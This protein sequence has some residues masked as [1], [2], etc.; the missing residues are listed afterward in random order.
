MDIT[1]SAEE[2][3]PVKSL[4]RQLPASIDFGYCSV[5]EPTVRTFKLFNHNPTDT[6]SFRF[7]PCA[8]RI[9][10]LTGSVSPGKSVTV[11]IE[12]ANNE[13]KI[14]ITKT[15]FSVDNEKPLTIKMSALFKYPYLQ[16]KEPL[17]DM[18]QWLV[19][20]Q[21]NMKTELLNPS[22]VPASFEIVR[23]CTAK[24]LDDHITC[25]QRSGVVPAHSSY[26]LDL[27]F[28]PKVAG[29]RSTCVFLVRVAGGIEQRM[30]V[31]GFSKS[32]RGHF[33]HQ[34][35]NFGSVKVESTTI[36]EFVFHND[37][38]QKLVFEFLDPNSFFQLSATKGEILPLSYV[39]IRV[40][41]CPTVA[42]NYFQRLFCLVKN[43]DLVVIEMA[44]SAF[45]VLQKPL[46]IERL[47]DP[48]LALD[49]PYATASKNKLFKIT[50]GKMEGLSK[51]QGVFSGVGRV[52]GSKAFQKTYLRGLSTIGSEN[53]DSLSKQKSIRSISRN[54]MA[55]PSTDSQ[56]LTIEKT[57]R[58]RSN[59]PNP[60]L[61]MGKNQTE[62]AYGEWIT[63]HF[64]V[65]DEGFDGSR[66]IGADLFRLFFD[67]HKVLNTAYQFSTFMLD[68]E[69][70]GALPHPRL[71]KTFA[72]TNHMEAKT[73][74]VVAVCR[75]PAFK[76]SGSPFRI[77]P[78]QTQE[79]SVTFSPE[80][81]NKFFVAH[82]SLVLCSE[83]PDFP[84][85]MSTHKAFGQLNP[86][87]TQ[88]MG[89]S[90]SV[91]PVQRQVLIAHETITL[92]GDSFSQAAKT[93]DQFLIFEP[94]DSVIFSHCSVGRPMYR[95]V[96]IR[97]EGD[98][99]CFFK[100]RC[101]S[102]HFAVYPAVG[103]IP[104][105]SRAFL[106]VRFVPDSD[107]TFNGQLVLKLNKT[108]RKAIA[109][110]AEI[111]N[112]N[113]EI[114]NAGNVVLPPGFLGVLRQAKF[115]L[116]NT[117][118]SEAQ[119]KL[120]VPEEFR[121]S[122]WF[123]PS[124]F[125][126][127]EGELKEVM[128]NFVATALASK[129][130]R[131]AAQLQAATKTSHPLLI[132]TECVDGR[133]GVSP[134][135]VD[136]GV[137]M[138]NFVQNKTI[139]IKNDSKTAFNVFLYPLLIDC[140][141]PELREEIVQ[142]LQVDFSEGLV[143]EYLSQTV[144]LTFHPKE[145]CAA[146]IRLLVITKPNH[147]TPKAQT[148]CDRFKEDIADLAAFVSGKI[149]RHLEMETKIK[150][151]GEHP[152]GPSLDCFAIKRI[153]GGPQPK[154]GDHQSSNEN[155]EAILQQKLHAYENAGFVI[156]SFCDVVLKSN[157]PLLKIV[158]ARCD[159]ESKAAIWER[160]QI[161]N[162][163]R[164]FAKSL[165]SFEKTVH[166]QSSSRFAHLPQSERL[167]HNFTW[168]F[169]FVY[170]QEIENKPRTVELFLQ[171]AGGTNLEWFFKDDDDLF[172]E[173]K[174]NVQKTLPP[175]RLGTGGRKKEGPEKGEHGG[176]GAMEQKR[177]FFSFK[178]K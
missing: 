102:A 45:D 71:T 82:L 132:S 61:L 110:Q 26:E 67:R 145:K 54:D 117:N 39:K 146:T 31:R 105:N 124:Q 63:K 100:A 138:V 15:V 68:F 16:V 137:V 140:D 167:S 126:V 119:V 13:A 52:G 55:G 92:T 114:E 115:S 27:T 30:E 129:Q 171:N 149:T 177:Q 46:Q 59:V 40:K 51:T 150:G 103:L 19:G 5:T 173:R 148:I 72:L 106:V 53:F 120:K 91:A 36:R 176:V 164:L 8:A 109:L 159:E 37:V 50:S 22:D 147:V 35:L 77:G 152:D 3:R 89:T 60:H 57:R 160:F 62:D 131:V 10:P 165:T 151:E 156:K 84:H 80:N 83:S 4:S 153:V 12:M 88:Q 64:K 169:G 47:L 133:I 69:G 98:V 44:G 86:L 90:G 11:R 24:Y 122:L 43:Q 32:I 127:Q 107:G 141:E 101:S 28:L 170:N 9:T 14:L 56:T 2:N 130:I 78:S 162:L 75:N 6:A 99:S 38:T 174:D 7:T 79:I 116:K 29:H 70:T 113:L 144:G 58:K 163:N 178:P 17:I 74:H 65:D 66:K 118:T 18:G 123:E 158:D 97:N 95:L 111:H 136:F 175:S 81:E 20:E 41:F 21:V 155:Q 85:Q 128:C 93:S 143:P 1:K 33:S 161:S 25:K 112:S 157:Y 73:L 49:K 135:R 172:S 34:Y 166:Q 23:E 76:V 94:E 154:N 121:D 48:Q 87:F 168:D 125:R 42:G 139:T 108:F 134:Q 96:T 104:R 142:D